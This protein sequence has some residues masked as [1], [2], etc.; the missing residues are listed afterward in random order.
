MEIIRTTLHGTPDDPLVEEVRWPDGQ[1]HIARVRN[2]ERSIPILTFIF[3]DETITP[4]QQHTIQTAF[5]ELYQAIRL[6]FSTIQFLG[7]WHE[8]A[9]RDNMGNLLPHKSITWQIKS[10]LNNNRGQINAEAITDTMLVD[11]YQL[12]HPHWE[13]VFTNY[14]LYSPDTRFIIGC[15]QPDIG[16]VISFHRLEAVSQ[17]GYNDAFKREVQKTEIFHEFG[18]VLGLP[19]RRRG[20]EILEQSLGA[21]CRNHG[22]SMR[23][24]LMVPLDWIDFTVERLK[25]GS[26]YCNDCMRDLDVKF[27]RTR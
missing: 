19:S 13:V 12:T 24:G 25:R 23:Q 1:T 7:N 10:K 22:C 8:S 3:W 4:A 15:A 14:D 9:Y 11:P 26:I 27:G 21:H 17:M 5:R 20:Q 6:D 18:H 2:P 16:T